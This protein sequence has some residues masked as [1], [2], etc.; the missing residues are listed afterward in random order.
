MLVVGLNIISVDLETAGHIEK[1]I[2]TRRVRAIAPWP[3]NGHRN[4]LVRNGRDDCNMALLHKGRE[5]HTF[6]YYS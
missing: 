4:R 5:V 3:P 6:L 1:R 2:N